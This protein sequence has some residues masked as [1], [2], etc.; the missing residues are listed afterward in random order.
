VIKR[1]I[2]ICLSAAACVIGLPAGAVSVTKNIDI[3]VTHSGN[4]TITGIIGC[5][6][7]AFTPNIANGIICNATATMSDGS[8]FAGSWSVV[9]TPTNNGGFHF[10]VNS[11]ALEQSGAGTAPGS[12]TDCSLVATPTNTA[13]SAFAKACNLIGTAPGSGPTIS[14][15][16]TSIASNSSPGNATVTYSGT[17][18]S[19]GSD[20]VELF[21]DYRNNTGQQWSGFSWKLPGFQNVAPGSTSG[22]M[23]YPLPASVGGDEPQKYFFRLSDASGK[24]IAVSNQ[25]TIAAAQTKVAPSSTNPGFPAPFTPAHTLDVCPSGCTYSKPSLAVNAA[26]TAGWDNVLV[27]IQAGLYDDCTYSDNIANL[28]YKGHG[29]NFARMSHTFLNNCHGKGMI[30]FA[31][32]RVTVENMELD[33]FGGVDNPSEAGVYLIGNS[34]ANLY[35]NYIH[36]SHQGFVNLSETAQV[37]MWNNHFARNGFHDT[38]N[39]Y[40]DGAS[41]DFRWNL[42]E[43]SG[44]H[45]VK[46]R[47]QKSTVQCNIINAAY[48]LAWATD[49]NANVDFSEGREAKLLDNTIGRGSFSPT[50]DAQLVGYAN[51]REYGNPTVG[52]FDIERN[53]WFDDGTSATKYFTSA[54]RETI[55]PFDVQAGA[56]CA[57]MNGQGC[58]GG[59]CTYFNHPVQSSFINNIGVSKP[60]A[61]GFSTEQT[62]GGPWIMPPYTDSGNIVYDTRAAA[63]AGSGIPTTGFPV[64]PACTAR[65]IGNVVIP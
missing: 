54:G 39:L 16:P 21:V 2:L 7:A 58:P 43:Q 55:C 38:H 34:S 49:G 45:A 30:V 27:S 51:D 36:D 28:W 5:D 18:H 25:V 15:S 52:Y 62:F 61:L 46:T 44:G 59:V 9:P 31:G 41:L 65:P 1:R 20:Y 13:I 40:A 47:A 29:G 42:T 3:I 17:P 24:A 60:T 8:T 57:N 12:Y 33:H 4:P 19:N 53:I 32:T 26:N 48:D 63:L 11:N 6:G 37:V 56:F 64:P 14:A 10:P 35:N 50:A 23:T 22:T